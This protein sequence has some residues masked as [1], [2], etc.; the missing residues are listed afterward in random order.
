MTKSD[1]TLDPPKVGTILTQRNPI[2]MGWIC[3]EEEMIQW[4]DVKQSATKK[5]PKF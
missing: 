2:L 1:L 5:A 3:L 4:L